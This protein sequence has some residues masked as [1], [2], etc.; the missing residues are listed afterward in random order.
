MNY[1]SLHSSQIEQDLVQSLSD[2]Y[3]E[4]KKYQH[5]I[6]VTQKYLDDH[7][8]DKKDYL[9]VHNLAKAFFN[10]GDYL[11]AQLYFRS[12]KALNSSYEKNYIALYEIY[13]ELQQIESAESVIKQGLK[14]TDRSAE[15][16]NFAGCFYI[17]VKHDAKRAILLFQ[18]AIAN[19]PF[20]A[21]IHNNLALAYLAIENYEE[22]VETLTGTIRLAPD[23]LAAYR[24]LALTYYRLNH[25]HLS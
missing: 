16:L 12:S 7:D 10:K 11:K 13:I 8:A 4:T 24:N 2:Y 3:L 22:A 23:Y 21:N 20:S 6:N 1:S 5:C 19:G 15:L 17:D 18:E 9:I 25:N 14:S